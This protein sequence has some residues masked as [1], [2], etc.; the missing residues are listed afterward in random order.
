LVGYDDDDETLRV[1]I[2][3]ANLVYGDLH[4]KTDAAYIQEFPRKQHIPS[5]SKQQQEQ[6]KQQQRADRLL[7]AD[8]DNDDGSCPFERDLLDYLQSYRYDIRHNW[9][10]HLTANPTATAAITMTQLL[11]QFDFRSARAI[12]IPSVPG[13]HRGDDNIHRYGHMKLRQAVRRQSSSSSSSSTS[14][15]TTTTSSGTSSNAAVVCQFSSMG[16]LHEKWLIGEFGA[17][18]TGRTMTTTATTDHNN[19]AVTNARIHLVYPTA[20]EV[21]CSVEGY[22]GG[23]ALPADTK[24]V[25]KASL[26]PLYHRW[27]PSSS[28]SSSSDNPFA[29]GRNLPHI[30]TFFRYNASGTGMQ[31]FVL[32]SHN[33]SSAAWGQ[34]QKKGQQFF[35]RHW[36]LGVFM[37]PATL[38]CRRLVPFV[39]SQQQQPL[40]RPN[41]ADSGSS[42]TC[43]HLYDIATV[44]LPY[45]FFPEKYQEGDVPWAWDKVFA[46][47]DQFGRHGL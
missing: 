41:T 25:E 3:T 20:D 43:D 11:S 9:D 32:T 12:L 36:E 7:L 46:K 33:I 37:S 5:L 22:A 39:L 21:R 26:R 1:V 35:C 10:N 6:Q 40:R 23:A 17:S 24:N 29:L 42:T 18:A 28:S 44:P 8:N 34:L 27:S 2:H 16:S 38:Q 14:R 45:Q 19:P 15:T 13:Y 30:K 47:S 31:W 4:L